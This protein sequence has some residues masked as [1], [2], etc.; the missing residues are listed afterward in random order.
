MDKSYA[1]YPWCGCQKVRTCLA[2]K[3]G[4]ENL[5]PDI[6]GA[7]DIGNGRGVAGG[8]AFFLF[9]QRLLRASPPH[10]NHQIIHST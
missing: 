7:K 5:C 9:L 8:E 6:F 10:S 3:C 4:E 1:V 2:C